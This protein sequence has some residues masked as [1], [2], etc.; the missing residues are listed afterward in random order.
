M[1]R[2][3][4]DG[5]LCRVDEIPEGRGLARRGREGR[6][7]ALFRDGGRVYALDDRCPHAGASLS[8]GWIE[9]GAVVCPLHR[10]RFRLRDGACVAGG[11][12]GVEPITVEVRDGEVRERS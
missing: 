12:E 7:L 8:S 3:N 10:W 9:G 2:S 4:G 5:S 6:N 11:D 1:A